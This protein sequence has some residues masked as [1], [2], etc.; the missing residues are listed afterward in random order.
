MFSMT[1]FLQ[2]ALAVAPPA[3]ESAPTSMASLLPEH[4]IFFCAVEDLSAFRASLRETSIGRIMAEEEVQE[5]LRQPLAALNEWWNRTAGIPLEGLLNSEGRR[6]FVALTR[7]DD[8]A[9]HLVVG[10]EGEVAPA[11]L[12]SPSFH[13]T[14][15]GGMPVYSQT[16]ET[17][18]ALHRLEA[19]GGPTLEGSPSFRA[20]LEALSGDEAGL[21]LYVK[22]GALRQFL[23]QVGMPDTLESFVGPRFPGGSIAG[24]L[25]PREGRTRTKVFLFDSNYY[26]AWLRRLSPAA[27]FTAEHLRLIPEDALLAQFFNLS[28]G[29]L[30][31]L[32]MSYEWID[33]GDLAPGM[34][35]RCIELA[36]KL[37]PRCLVAIPSSPFNPAKFLVSIEVAEEAQLM[38]TLTSLIEQASAQARVPL[39]LRSLEL[40]GSRVYQLVSKRGAQA[41]FMF[42]MQ[43][44]WVTAALDVHVMKRHLRRLA[45]QPTGLLD[46]AR[47]AESWERLTAGGRP[48]T[49]ISY[50]ALPRLYET[51]VSY[52]PLLC[53]GL[54]ENFGLELP[55]DLLSLPVGE[56][57]TRHLRSTIAVSRRLENGWFF[58]RE[59][60]LGGELT[61]MGAALLVA[62]MA[63][64]VNDLTRGGE[65]SRGVVTKA[66]QENAR[67]R[68][69][70]LKVGV[71]SYYRKNGRLPESLEI[72]TQPDPRNSGECYIDPPSA[73][74][75]PWGRPYSYAP[76]GRRSFRIL[77]YGAD[78][79]PGGEGLNSDIATYTPW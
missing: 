33:P 14:T 45:G 70:T 61:G 48:V 25:V 13:T 51:A 69:S 7:H 59:G 31:H 49:G 58:E 34:L 12:A 11:C 54:R 62:R 5:C 2:L 37:G 16:Q 28:P 77:T 63:A 75:D 67:K 9:M 32:L 4:T 71:A 74:I 1:W 76:T 27:A 46:D 64:W 44:G 39:T 42:A 47:I 73:V 60:S 36:E 68:L 57:V 20:S 23:S 15:L 53:K 56:V 17:L 26:D 78:G 40:D 19:E 55:L 29:S 52:L 35:G 72:L 30:L 22:P 18:A 3:Q 43:G 38:E 66:D 24:L 6:M 65:S 79:A 41:G 8:G 50:C 21:F 10:F